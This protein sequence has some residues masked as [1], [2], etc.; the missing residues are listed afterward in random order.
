MKISLQT[1]TEATSAKKRLLPSS[2]I[3]EAL[4]SRRANHRR[5]RCSYRHCHCYHCHCCHCRLLPPLPLPLFRCSPTL[6]LR[7]KAT[8]LLPRPSSSRK[9]KRPLP[10]QEH[11]Q[12]Q[13]DED[14]G[15]RGDAASASVESSKRDAAG[16]D[17]PTQRSRGPTR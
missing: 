3:L 8:S 17:H 16:Q 2:S 1:W 14:L 4:G 10:D 11:D 7:Q 5:A 6:P 12:E 15:L 9:R 13:I